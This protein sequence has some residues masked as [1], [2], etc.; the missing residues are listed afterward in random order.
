MLDAGDSPFFSNGVERDV[1]EVL[2]FFQ[3]NNGPAL[4]N[5]ATRCYAKLAF[6]LVVSAV[7]VQR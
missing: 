1:P 3:A 5:K 2:S 7:R 4:C 6:N